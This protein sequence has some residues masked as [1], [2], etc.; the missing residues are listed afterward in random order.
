M[1]RPPL[2]CGLAAM[3]GT[4]PYLD[5]M[6]GSHPTAVMLWGEA[7]HPNSRGR[8]VCAAGVPEVDGET[9]AGDASA[10]RFGTDPSP[11]P[12]ATPPLQGGGSSPAP[13]AADWGDAHRWEGTALASPL[14]V[15]P[16]PL[17]KIISSGSHFGEPS[18]NLF[19][20][21]GWAPTGP[22]QETPLHSPMG[23]VR[24]PPSPAD[25]ERSIPGSVLHPA[26]THQPLCRSGAEP[27]TTIQTQ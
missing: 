2:T 3:L 5:G 18:L 10:G 16:I 17:I 9:E 7:Q 25:G 4:P 21:G 6:G 8:A 26:V 1:A 24:D 11:D 23:G 12:A 19:A 14:A 15:A 27:V 22:P 20:A 13:M